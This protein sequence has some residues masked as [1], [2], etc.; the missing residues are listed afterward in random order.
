LPVEEHEPRAL[1]GGD[2]QRGGICGHS[3]KS[4]ARVFAKRR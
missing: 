4:P 1:L 2:E 3:R